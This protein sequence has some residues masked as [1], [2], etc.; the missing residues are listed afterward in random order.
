MYHFIRA[1]S[2]GN[3]AAII[4]LSN[5]AGKGLAPVGQFR[6]MSAFGALDVAGNAREWCQNANGN[7][8]LI[9]GGA[10]NDPAYMFYLAYHLDP[11]DRS[12]TNGFRVARYE[13]ESAAALEAPVEE[14][15]RNFATERPVSDELFAAYRRSYD[16]DRTQLDARIEHMDTAESWIRQRVTF[17]AAYG[18]E[19]VIGYMFL[20]RIGRPPY[21]T[22]VYYP[23]AGAIGNALDAPPG[24]QPNAFLTKSGRAVLFPIYK[25]TYERRDAL[26]AGNWYPNASN[27]Y[28]EHVIMWAK[29]L[30]RALDYLFSR[31]DVDTTRLAYHGNSWGGYSSGIMLAVEPRFRAAILQCPGLAFE[32]PQPEVDQVNFLPRIRIPVL[33][34]DGRY[35]AIFPLERSSLP[36]FRLLGTSPDQKKQVVVDSGHCPPTDVFVS[37]ALA[38]LDKYLGPVR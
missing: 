34:V 25:S 28:R 33:M 26:A 8:R 24:P 38:W 17:T 20:P 12:P 18:G 31:P 11:F 4:P 32:R 21:Q 23:G 5:T 19:R 13:D 3:G 27:F 7:D 10:W 2:T 37:E 36:M 35:D 30:R 14:R 15:L 1:A 16:Y 9:L 6:G 22:V 29:D